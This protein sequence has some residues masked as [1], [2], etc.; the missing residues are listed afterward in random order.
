MLY[1]A[2]PSHVQ[3]FDDFRTNPYI[4]PAITGFDL[5]RRLSEA[6]IPA[7]ISAGGAEM[8][9]DEI[10]VLKDAMRQQGMDVTYTEVRRRS[11]SQ[12]PR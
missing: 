8:L 1:V 6:R 12:S 3:H 11:R 4:C 7:Y 9:L 5:F 10:V 2:R